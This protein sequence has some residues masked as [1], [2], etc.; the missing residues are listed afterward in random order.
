MKMLLSIT[1]MLSI[2]LIPFSNIYALSQDE[3]A[4]LDAA[5]FGDEDIIEKIIDKNIN[6]N[7]QDD[8]GNTALILA[9]MGGH[10]KSVELL[11]KA[12]ADKL[13]ANKYGNNALFYAKQKNYTDIIKLLE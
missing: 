9:S 7:I 6:I 10:I 13:I 2:I 11:I 8:V 5:V 1:M 12:N 4:F 3:E